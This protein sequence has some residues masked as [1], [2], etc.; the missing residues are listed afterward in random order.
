M[1]RN[2]LMLYYYIVILLQCYILTQNNMFPT[3]KDI[4]QNFND[5]SHLAAPSI[6]YSGENW[7]TLHRH[8]D[9]N[10]NHFNLIQ[11]L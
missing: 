2:S 3:S 1:G 6:C 5:Y 11:T 7:L 10:L 8:S 4:V 9:I